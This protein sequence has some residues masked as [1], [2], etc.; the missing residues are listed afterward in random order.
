MCVCVGGRGGSGSWL[1]PQD[2]CLVGVGG[3][4]CSSPGCYLLSVWVWGAGMA[5]ERL[6]TQ[7]LRRGRASGLQPLTPTAA[8]TPR[9]I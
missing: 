3:L 7:Q 5:A 9:A 2:C 6:V 8:Q 4:A 1:Q